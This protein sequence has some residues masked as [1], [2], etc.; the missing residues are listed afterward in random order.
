MGLVGRRRCWSVC[1][2]STRLFASARR[3]TASWHAGWLAHTSVRANKR[4]ATM[5]TS[6]TGTRATSLTRRAKSAAVCQSAALRRMRGCDCAPCAVAMGAGVPA[7]AAKLDETT[8]TAAVKPV[9]KRSDR[10]QQM[11]ALARSWQTLAPGLAGGVFLGP[12]TVAPG[13]R[14]VGFWVCP[15][16]AYR[17]HPGP[18]SA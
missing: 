13:P 7:Q 8:R 16:Q 17:L 15:W 3:R 9:V 5:L 1:T 11:L 4:G 18:C 2:S 14:S 6:R 12:A 10:M